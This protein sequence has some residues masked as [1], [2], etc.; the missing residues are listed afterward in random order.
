MCLIGF[1]IHKRILYLA[2]NEACLGRGLQ[3]DLQEVLTPENCSYHRSLGSLL[4]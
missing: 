4:G 1:Y 2:Q 3:S